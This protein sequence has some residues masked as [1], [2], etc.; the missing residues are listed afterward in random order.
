MCQSMINVYVYC[1]C[2]N[3]TIKE[4]SIVYMNV[5]YVERLSVLLLLLFYFMYIIITESA[6][7][8]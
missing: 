6:K 2:I 4:K 5:F 1:K 7:T 8:T 3:K